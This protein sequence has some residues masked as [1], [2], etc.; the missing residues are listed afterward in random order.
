MMNQITNA[1][2]TDSSWKILYRVG[3]VA[4]F[5]AGVVFRRNLGREISLF[6]EQKPPVAVVDWFEMLQKNVLLG[7]SY[8]NVAD[9]I[10][11]A[12]LS[13][14]F[15]ALY[16]AL[17]RTNKSSMIIATVLGIMG[18]TV[19]FASNTAF[20]MLS[21]S[22]QYAAA[23]TDAQRS[24]LLAAGQAVLA[25]NDPSAVYQGTGIYISFLLLA[26]AGLIVSVVMLRSGIFGRVTALVGIVASA[27]DL[28][29]CFTF[30]CMPLLPVYL[31]STAGLLLMVWHILVGLRLLQLGRLERKTLLR[32][33]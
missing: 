3:G 28:V 24:M 25:I 9:I 30:A 15:L 14:M 31:L 11:Y 16:A 10:N 22:D 1:D 13:L 18:T 4:A 2:I 5:V 27:C 17:R 33:S 29:Y 20:S 23:T 7:L 6:S 32:Q 21:L 19:Y 12:L 8:L 26:V